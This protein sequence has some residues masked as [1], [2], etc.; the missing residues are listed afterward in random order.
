MAMIPPERGLQVAADLQARFERT[1]VAYKTVNNTPIETAIFVP[2]TLSSGAGAKTDAPVPVLVHFHG[3][4]LILGAFPEP[5]FLTD[6]VRDLV[7]TTPCIFVSPGYRLIP[8]ARAVDILDDVADFWTWL[9]AHL[10][11]AIHARWPHLTPD[12]ARVAAVGESAG[13]YL[14]LQSALLFNGAAK[15]RA[16]IAQYPAMYPDLAGFSP[17]PPAA[18][19]ALAAVVTDYIKAIQPGAVRVSTPWPEKAELVVAAV[20]SGLI[21]ELYG[22]DKEGRLTLAYALA[23]A[24]EVPPP[25]WVIQGDEDFMV[26]KAGADEMVER[27]KKE[28]P[29]AVVKYTVRPGGHGFDAIDTLEDDWVKEGVDFA[30]GYWLR[31]R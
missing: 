25:I 28:R 31:L 9:H 13:G 24:E 29:T 5:F 26:P 27:M 19:P 4:G 8:E 20:G 14:A 18:D 12:L 3:G 1:D 16:V 30:K 21:R 23:K 22:E 15:L 7:H 2:S 11:A 6:W 10:P 17:S